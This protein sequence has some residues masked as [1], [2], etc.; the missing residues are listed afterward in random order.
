[1]ANLPYIP[2]Q[3]LPQL[4]EAV[5]KFEP[6]S[7]LDGGVDGVSF[8]RQLLKQAPAHLSSQGV[9]ICEID[10]T[11]NSRTFQEFSLRYQLRIVKDFLGRRRF[12]IGQLRSIWI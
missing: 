9:I 8:I 1:M 5:R 3:R 11:H 2:S 7:A 4:P 12:L 10:H 6:P